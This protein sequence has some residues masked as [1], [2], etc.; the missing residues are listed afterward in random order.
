MFSWI[1][2]MRG[3]HELKGFKV[4]IDQVIFNQCCQN[5]K[6]QSLY[7]LDWLYKQ[8]KKELSK[9]YI[10]EFINWRNNS[11]LTTLGHPAIVLPKR[12]AELVKVTFMKNS[13][14]K[15]GM[16]VQ[17]WVFFLGGGSF[18]YSGFFTVYFCKEFLNSECQSNNKKK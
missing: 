15:C 7:F 9:K 4:S 17:V 12:Y 1:W 13:Q 16:Q 8:W 6:N 11:P 10:F 18:L 2:I 5:K 14:L 3:R